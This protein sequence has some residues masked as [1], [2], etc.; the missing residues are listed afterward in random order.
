MGQRRAVIIGAGPAGLTAAYELLKRTDIKPVVLEKSDVLGGIARTVNYKGYRMDIGGHR[1]FSKSDRVMQWWLEMLP[2]QALNPGPHTI[3]Y[4]G[5]R[6]TVE[7]AGSGPDPDR[8]DRVMLVRPRKSRI[9]FLRRFFEYPIRLTPETLANLGVVRSIR[10]GASYLR[11]A[12]FPIRNPQTLE[13]FFINRFGRELYLTFFKSYTE[14]VWGVPCH[15]ISAEWGEQ[16]IKGLSV[17]K[18]I[19]HFM[20]Q[21]L[22]K[23]SDL[24]QKDIETSLIEQFLYPKFGPGQMWEEVAHRVVT[25][26]GE[27][28]KGH[29]VVGLQ[30][31]GN[32]VTAVEAANA[33][34]TMV[35]GGDY[36]FSTMPV[37]D[38]VRALRAPHPREIVEIAEGLVYRDFIAVG[39]LVRNLKVKDPTTDGARL[40]RDNWIYIQEPDVLVGRLQIFNNWSPYL[41][42]DPSKV[43]LGLEYFC[44]EG[45]SL[46]Q[47]SD[48]ELIR[49][50]S[51]ELSRI[52]IIDAQ[53][54]LDGT[55]VRMQ[56]TYP[57]YFGTYSRFEELRRYLDRFENLFLIGRNG[58]H[59]YN[60]QDHSMLA[61]MVAVDNIVG[62]IRSKDNIWAVNTEQEYIE[63]K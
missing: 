20:K 57:A 15:Q 18:T 33:S 53:D 58:M 51:E 60:N 21:A 27:I 46:W 50:G 59:R 10:I 25:M 2:L 54:V 4:Q 42:P 16:R 8:E 37:R 1:F 22:R 19:A 28:L 45:D 40:I 13:E 38:L 36:F 55:V 14:K 52:G 30:T 61:A 41:V 5:G 35:L 12:L 7:T 47:M 62:G 3:S 26:G 63:E 24:A 32:R 44:N 23:R 48:E 31:D 39:L 43:W 6:R 9:Y 56:K 17:R 34:G 49:L 11:S 29:E